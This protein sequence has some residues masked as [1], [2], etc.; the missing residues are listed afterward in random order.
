MRAREV[1]GRGALVA[2]GLSVA[3]GVLEILARVGYEPAGER[4]DDFRISTSDFYQ[5]DP[6][7][8]WRPRPQVSGVHERRRSFR[9]TFRTNSRGLRDRDYPLARVPGLVRIVVLGDS[10]TWGYGVND[11]EVFTERLEALLDS[12]EVINLGVAAYGLAQEI[13]YL[14]REGFLYNPDMVILA[15]C[16]NDIPEAGSTVEQIVL[17]RTQAGPGERARGGVDPRGYLRTRSSLYHFVSD[18]VNTNPHLVKAL[19]RLGLKSPLRGLEQLDPSLS[20]ALVAPPPWLQ[21]AWE[22]TGDALMTLKTM[23]AQR[24]IVLVVAVIPSLQSVS[25]RA[26]RQSIAYSVAREHDFDL[27]KPYR[28]LRELA[29][30]CGAVFVDPVER[31]RA[32]AAAGARLYLPRDMHLSAEGHLLLAKAIAEAIGP[33]VEALRPRARWPR[34][35]VPTEADPRTLGRAG[36]SSSPS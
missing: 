16:L 5:P 27:D 17:R 7:L 3:L 36:S 32:S 24:G 2:L 31:F 11:Q 1:L 22:A 14:R 23:T 6:E 15:L 9:S 18:R 35:G 8:G 28:V 30:G 20:P 29:T 25:R 10:F 26:F 33:T 19:I 13:A 12:V 4:I 34:E 21:E